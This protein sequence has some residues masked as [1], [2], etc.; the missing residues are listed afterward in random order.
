MALQTNQ[1]QFSGRHRGYLPWFAT[2]VANFEEE[3]VEQR[4]SLFD[5]LSLGSRQGRFWT[6]CEMGIQLVKMGEIV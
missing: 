3:P 5:V 6:H 2:T 1:H 4:C